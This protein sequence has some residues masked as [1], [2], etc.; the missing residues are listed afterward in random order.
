MPG[1]AWVYGNLLRKLIAEHQVDCWLVNTGWTGGKY[2][3]GSRMPIKATRALLKAA[4][5]GEL[6]AQAMRT[7]PVF[8]FQVPLGLNGIDAKILTPRDTWADT[9]AY[10]AMA[11]RLVEMFQHNFERF[12]A[13]VDADVLAAGP[14]LARTVAAE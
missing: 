14:I 11:G 7:D 5:T 4:L 10:D 1:P 13:Y 9:A 12:A 2:G 3:T 8:G 6:K